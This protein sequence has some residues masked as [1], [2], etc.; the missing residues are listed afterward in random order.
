[1]M[2]NNMNNQNQHAR[3]RFRVWDVER[4]AIAAAARQFPNNWQRI[5]AAVLQNGDPNIQAAYQH[6]NQRAQMRRIQDV[7]TNEIQRSVLDVNCLQH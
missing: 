2:A 7:L 3:R 5:L 4:N 6:R 1:M